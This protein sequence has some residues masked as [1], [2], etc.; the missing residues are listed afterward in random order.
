MK[1]DK[2]TSP[3]K[4]FMAGYYDLFSWLKESGLKI[5]DLKEPLS[6]VNIGDFV[7][8]ATAVLAKLDKNR[9]PASSV[10]VEDLFAMEGTEKGIPEGLQDAEG[11]PP[12]APQKRSLGNTQKRPT[13]L[14]EED[15]E[16]EVSPLP[17]PVV[18]ASQRKQVDEDEEEDAV[19]APAKR[20]P[21]VGVRREAD[22]ERAEKGKLERR[23]KPRGEDGEI[24]EEEEPRERTMK[25][26][27]PKAKQLAFDAEEE[28]EGEDDNSGFSG[29]D[30]N[31]TMV[32]P[33][34]KVKIYLHNLLTD[35]TYEVDDGINTIGRMNSCNIC[36]D[37]ESVSKKHAKITKIGNDLFISDLGSSNGTLVNDRMLEAGEKVQLQNQDKIVISDFELQLLKKLP[38]KMK[39]KK[40]L[41]EKVSLRPKHL[42]KV[43]IVVLGCCFLAAVGFVVYRLILSTTKPEVKVL[44]VTR[45]MID[46]RAEFTG[47]VK[48]YREFSYACEID[49]LVAKFPKVQ[50]DY[51]EKGEVVLELNKDDIQL[52]INDLFNAKK[53]LEAKKEAMDKG[54]FAEQVKDLM[55]R[56]TKL[57]KLR[58]EA[59]IKAPFAGTITAKNIEAGGTALEPGKPLM[60]LVDYDNVYLET[61]LDEDTVKMI[62]Q[63]DSFE[64]EFEGMKGKAKA[65]FESLQKQDDGKYLVVLQVSNRDKLYKPGMKAKITTAEERDKLLI[66]PRKAV[67]T[68]KGEGQVYV[69]NKDK[70]SARK[71]DVKRWFKDEVLVRSGLEEGEE[72]V[73]SD[74]T[75]LKA[76]AEVVK[77]E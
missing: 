20:K 41:K 69:F 39:R 2:L 25:K 50:N 5:K 38:Q 7:E 36:I 52:K 30:A 75:R 54:E 61:K 44:A 43:A 40:P 33:A 42:L 26:E 53:D 55:I 8:D 64:L 28:E 29:M 22:E 72:I 37:D 60:I 1:F 23:P 76:G 9:G 51:V 32:M 24:E 63:T 73:I 6:K 14:G 4:K 67:F 62:D 12:P 47:E 49:C 70:L 31:K 56:V 3:G 17:P 34:R 16:A 11:T 27:K 46:Q 77:V 13:P 59:D 35:E 58:K 66:V 45:G 15:E 10:R 48:S 74:L 68:V 21:T 19:P 65:A 71:L 57:A 18:K